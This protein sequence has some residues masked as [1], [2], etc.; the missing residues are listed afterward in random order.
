MSLD[1]LGPAN[2]PNAVTVR[3]ADTRTFGAADTWVKDCTS[4][5]IDDGTDIQAGF[6][7][8]LIGAWRNL[9]RGNGQTA[10][11]VDIVT[12]DNADD[13]MALKSVK[14]MIQRGQAPYSDDSGTANHVI[15]TLDPAPAELKKG[16]ILTSKIAATCTGASDLQV[17]VA[18][19]SVT[20]P[21]KHIDGSDL[22]QNDMLAAS[23]QAFGFDGTNFQLIWL[24][25]QPGVPVYLTASKTYYVGGTGASDSNDGLSATVTGGHG[26][27][28][29]LQH[30]ENVIAGYN[31]NGFSIA[32][33]VAHGSFAPIR[34]LAVAGAGGVNY[35]GDPTSPGSC[36]IS[37][38]GLAQTCITAG[39]CGAA[40]TFN[41]FALTTS[42]TFVS[43]PMN[44]VHVYGSGTKVSLSNMSYGAC[45]GGH[46]TVEQGASLTIL[47][48]ET[49]TGGCAGSTGGN[50]AHANC[51][52][53]GQ[54]QTPAPIPL[55]VTN[56]VSFAAGWF[57]SGGCAL[58]QLL[59]STIT[60]GSNV[61]GQRY[62]VSQNAV[63]SSNGGGAN[64]YPG[65]VAGVS[66]SGGQYV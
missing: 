43:D 19:G 34:L 31:L 65:T 26:P 38:A 29:T 2:A 58:G 33:N 60:G 7:N 20:K 56:A 27:W 55:T 18:G 17:N 8:A 32:I 36:V 46:Y 1:I 64:Y 22:N 24:Q 49:V 59:Y 42:G 48:T 50:G 25:R 45:P 30:A 9:I 61:T 16:M 35:I 54:L 3:P 44:G 41:G 51:S 13:S 62:T 39:D 28:A 5:T 23:L 53:T 40:H 52:N 21:I 10:A 47:G 63:I 12:Q 37:G 6:V 4:D 11:G 57:T 66:S 14:H 15:L